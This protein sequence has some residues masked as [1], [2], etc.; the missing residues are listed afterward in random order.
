MKRTWMAWGM[1]LLAALLIAACGGSSESDGETTAAGDSATETTASAGEGSRI[2]VLFPGTENDLQW[3]QSFSEG[4]AAAAE[5]TGAEVSLAPNLDTPDQ[6]MDQAASYASEGYDLVLLANGTVADV[7]AK[8]ARQFPDTTF[9]QG[10][11][12]LQETEI[13]DLPEN[14]CHFDVEQQYSAFLGGVLAGLVTKSNKVGSVNG[15]V[16]PALTRQPEAFELGARCVNPQIKMFN[17]EMDGWSDPALGKA[18]AQALI[19]KGVDVMLAPLHTAQLGL[20]QAAQANPGTKVITEYFSNVEQGPDVIIA[21][22]LFDFQSVVVDLVERFERG[23]L[24]EEPFISYDTDGGQLEIFD[25]AELSGDQQAVFDRVAQ[26]VK[27]GEIEIPDEAVGNPTIG[28]PG[29]AAK[30]DVKS[31]GCDPQTI[32]GTA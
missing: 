26:M 2:A 23:E 21:T 7:A 19:G 22:A 4:A 1:A 3:G 15:F 17:Q 8:L 14:L 10:V 30:I 13:A 27:D 31:I 32:G 6:Y 16:F 20:I 5:A 12:Q 29:S 24:S 25:G 9:C 11:I 18:A 28:E